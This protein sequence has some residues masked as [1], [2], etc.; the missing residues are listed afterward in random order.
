MQITDYWRAPGTAATAAAGLTLRRAAP[1]EDDGV[2]LELSV[3][4]R[5]LAAEMA[6]DREWR[7]RLAQGI[8]P[9]EV[10]AIG[11]FTAAQ[12]PYLQ[13]TWGPNTGY[14]WAVQRITV[15]PLGALTD[16]VTVYKGRSAADIQ[17]QNALFTFTNQA[18]G[19]GTWHPGTAGLILMPDESI[20]VAGTITGVNP[21]LNWDAIQM[22][23]WFLPH[24]L[25]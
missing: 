5:G 19:F 23:S 24:F 22:E 20:V 8:M 10:P 11:A 17:S 13:G 2:T 6:A 4:L 25:K 21:M 12:T 7:D 15:G 3:S 1:A 16:A 18:T 9:I 14:A